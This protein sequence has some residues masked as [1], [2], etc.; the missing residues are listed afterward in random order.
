LKFPAQA[1]FEDDGA[2]VRLEDD[3]PF[4]PFAHCPP[5]GAPEISQ[6]DRIAALGRQHVA[7]RLRV[8][9]PA[10]R[11]RYPQRPLRLPFDSG[12][13]SR[14][15]TY[16]IPSISRSRKGAPSGYRGTRGRITGS[17]HALGL[18]YHLG[19]PHRIRFYKREAE[20]HGLRGSRARGAQA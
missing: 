4:A 1:H 6:S 15:S 14:F 20:D 16:P 12:R 7:D 10:A 5:E 17:G 19:E 18:D 13:N 11:R 9:L 8:S 3:L 2:L